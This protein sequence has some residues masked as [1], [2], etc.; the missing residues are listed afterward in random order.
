M[1]LS[2]CGANHYEGD[3]YAF[4]NEV[5][6]ISGS[7]ASGEIHLKVKQAG[8]MGQSGRYDYTVTLALADVGMLIRHLA[9]QSSAFRDGP[10]RTML[11]EHTHS[12]VRLLIAAGGAAEAATAS[13]S[14]K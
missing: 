12:F 2:R 7:A 14:S 13:N 6:G 1:D 4:Q 8:G 11:Q 5:A 10:L 3:S 9:S